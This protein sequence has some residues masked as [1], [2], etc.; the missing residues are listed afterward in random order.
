MPRR[1][2]PERSRPSGRCWDRQHPAWAVPLSW[3]PLFDSFSLGSGFEGG[4]GF[5]PETVEPTAQGL[6]AV[7]FN[8]VQASRAFGTNHD[9]SCLLEHLQVLRDSGTAH[10]HP[11]GNL[12]H[13][14]RAMAQTLEY[15]A[16]RAISESVQGFLSLGHCCCLTAHVLMVSV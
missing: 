10:I 8:R 16:P 15:P 12:S 11:V 9:Q 1:A 5:I 2:A 7:R 4:E 6:Y 3:F 13:R 14:A